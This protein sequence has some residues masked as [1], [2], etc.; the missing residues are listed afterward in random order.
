MDQ[1]HVVRFRMRARK[2]AGLLKGCARN[3][4]LGLV[5]PGVLDLHHRRTNRHHDDG[6]NAEPPGM[7]GD[8]LR[9]VARRHRHDATPTLV[10]RQRLQAI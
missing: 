10:R 3:D 5:P 8:A 1:G 7:V 6:G 2:L 4:D 9:V